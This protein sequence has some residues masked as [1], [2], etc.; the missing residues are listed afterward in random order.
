MTEDS[1]YPITKRIER[2]DRERAEMGYEPPLDENE[3][4]GNPIALFTEWLNKAVDAKLAQPVGFTLATVG[5]D[6]RPAARVMLLRAV[7]ERGLSFFTNYESRKGRELEANPCAAMCFWWSE[8]DRQV[9][10]EG[11]IER[12]PEAESAE[13][14]G[15]RPRGSRIAAWASAQSSRI[16]SRAALI[17]SVEEQENKFDT[18][19]VPRPE[20]WGGYRLVP[21]SFEFWQEGA[22]RLHDR[23]RFDRREDGGAWSITRLAP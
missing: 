3:I 17:R 19:V 8:L 11:R 5:A 20:N 2:L 4:E 15:K 10:I 16:E 13:Y 21:E 12:C 9:R 1:E 22:F 14:F 7:E 18:D 6:G 23:L